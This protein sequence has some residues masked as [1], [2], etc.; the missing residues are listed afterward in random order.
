MFV[1]SIRGPFDVPGAL[2]LMVEAS[3]EAPLPDDTRPNV[4][5]ALTPGTSQRW[6]LQVQG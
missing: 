4:A 3:L 2:E 1:P 5:E 6:R